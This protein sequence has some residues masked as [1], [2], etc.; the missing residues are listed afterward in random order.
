MNH[1]QGTELRSALMATA[2]EAAPQTSG[3][4]GAEG[5]PRGEAALR[6]QLEHYRNMA[7]LSPQV[8]WV[9]D[10]EGRLFDFSPRWLELTGQT[11]EQALTVGWSD[12]PHPDDL[13]RMLPA[14][15]HSISTGTPLDIEHRIRVA[16]GSYRWMRTRAYP[17]RDGQ[18]EIVAWHGYTED[19]DRRIRVEKALQASEARYRSV[20]E[21]AQEGVW[22]VDAEYRTTFV[23]ARM[24]DM[25][26]Y[27]AEE[28]IGRS[29]D[30]FMPE[31]ERLAFR[32][33]RVERES[34]DSSQYDGKYVRKDG[35]DLGSSSPP[36]PL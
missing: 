28:M 21:T 19:V 9:A 2:S 16:D 8:P 11:R 5:D 24:A 15:T 29:V 17:R 33:R 22:M 6:A 1:D 26:G 3:D 7:E 20:V 4:E 12:V 34:G 13:P 25:L 30:D 23:N 18:G 27:A 32:K 31:P 36:H 35:S 10:R 14:W